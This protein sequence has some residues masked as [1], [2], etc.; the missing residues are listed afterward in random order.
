M[1]LVSKLG[2]GAQAQLQGEEPYIS[3][4][5]IAAAQ[6]VHVAKVGNEPAVLGAGE[7]MRLYDEKLCSKWSGEYHLFDFLRVVLCFV[8]P[9]S[10]GWKQGESSEGKEGG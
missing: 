1:W 2:G 3:A 5:L 7:D 4:P 8:K 9:W 6:E 10:H